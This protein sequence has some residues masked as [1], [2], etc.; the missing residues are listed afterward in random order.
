MLRNKVGI[1]KMITVDGLVLFHVFRAMQCPC[2]SR[3][4][5][6]MEWYII[7]DN[8]KERSRDLPRDLPEI[9]RSSSFVS[10]LSLLLGLL[11]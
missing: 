9:L 3:E 8:E 6:F 11:D 1:K 2:D 5:G 10:F 7:Q 4:Q